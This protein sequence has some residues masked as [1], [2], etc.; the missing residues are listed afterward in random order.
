ME[1]YNNRFANFTGRST[2]SEYGH[3][4]LFNI[5]VVLVI[6]SMNILTE[7]KMALF[8][9]LCIFQLVMFV[10]MQAVTIRRLRDLGMKWNFIFWNF[11]PFFNFLLMLYLLITPGKRG[12]NRYGEDP[13][14]TLQM[15]EFD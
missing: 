4:I 12:D 1:W 2:R 7:N 11:M 9:N 6:Y 5:V 15:V 10:P 8:F 13:K 14:M 3:Y